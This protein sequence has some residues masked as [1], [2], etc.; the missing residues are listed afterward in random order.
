MSFKT[1]TLPAA[2]RNAEPAVK[3]TGWILARYGLALVIGWIGVCKFYPYEAHNIE[4]L[5]ANSP[6]M[7]WLYTVF[8]V[9][10]FSTMLGVLEIA[11]ALLIIAKPRFPALSAVGSTVA[12]L[13][14]ASTLSFL[15]TT[16]GVG[17][18]SAGGFPLLSM[19]GQFLIKDVVL[20]GVSVLTL[21][22][23][24]GAIVHG[25]AESPK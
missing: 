24:I 16:P 4:P 19:T 2:L 17:E 5:V 11:T 22:D 23:S 6:F 18:P 14:F 9:Q 20:I 3:S 10:T 12:V 7:G 1:N 21:A 15:F 13:L 25:A 8:S